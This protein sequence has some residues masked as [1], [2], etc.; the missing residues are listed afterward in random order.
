MP[1]VDVAHARSL[2]PALPSGPIRA[3]AS[4]PPSP[5]NAALRRDLGEHCRRRGPRGNRDARGRGQVGGDAPARPAFAARHDARAARAARA[6]RSSRACPSSRTRPRTGSS[7]DAARRRTDR[8]RRQRAPRR[9]ATLARRVRARRRARAPTRSAD[10]RGCPRAPRRERIE[11]ARP[12]GGRAEHPLRPLARSRPCRRGAA[13]RRPRRGTRAL[14]T[15][16]CA[17]P[18]E[19]PA[20]SVRSTANRA[21]ASG[22]RRDDRARRRPCGAPSR[23]RS[24]RPT[25]RRRQSGSEPAG[26]HPRASGA[27]VLAGVIATAGRRRRSS[28]R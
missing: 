25:R 11:A 17:Q 23:A 28:G 10:R 22:S 3:A 21:S 13:A 12:F 7:T 20:N 18:L 19:A 26:A 1:N 6:P 5:R 24:P 4:S 9:T 14:R 27:R 8:R 15:P 2:R 16:T